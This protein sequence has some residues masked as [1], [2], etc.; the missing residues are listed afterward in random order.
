MAA[1]SSARCRESEEKQFLALQLL[2]ARQALNR[3]GWRGG[4]SLPRSFR[5]GKGL[6]REGIDW[7][8]TVKSGGLEAPG[9]CGDFGRAV[10]ERAQR[11][12]PAGAGLYMGLR[13]G[14]E[15]PP[16]GSQD[17]IDSDHRKGP[18]DACIHTGPLLS[19]PV[20]GEHT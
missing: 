19:D 14:W 16:P 13:G 4:G 10:R 8:C 11:V 3:V 7:A 9:T 6:K 12:S 5:K 2:L 18:L 15:P 17:Q 20:I 1:R